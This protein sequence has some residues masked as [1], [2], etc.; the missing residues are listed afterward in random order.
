VIDLTGKVEVVTLN[1]IDEQ[2]YYEQSKTKKQF[3]A[4][5][6]AIYDHVMSNG[7]VVTVKITKGKIHK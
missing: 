7:S 1:G 2:F 5:M 4:N 3:L 6:G